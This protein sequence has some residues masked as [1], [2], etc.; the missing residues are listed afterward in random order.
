MKLLQNAAIVSTDKKG[1]KES[2]KRH[3]RNVIA[4]HKKSFNWINFKNDTIL[5]VE[6]WTLKQKQK[7]PRLTLEI[8][9]QYKAYNPTWKKMKKCNLCLN[10]KLV[11]IDDLDKNLLNKRSEVISQCRHWNK[12][13]LVN[14][15]WGKT[16]NGVI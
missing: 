1:T 10:E 7:P 14:L 12:F 5:S 2:V 9:G 11:I 16:P 15:T 13:R 8:K 3:S 4:N 6:Y